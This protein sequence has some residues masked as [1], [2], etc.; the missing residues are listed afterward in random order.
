MTFVRRAVLVFALALAG[1]AGAEAPTQQPTLEARCTALP[2]A[3]NEALQAALDSA[4]DRAT[5]E[6]F[7]GQVAVI[8]G[9]AFI[10]SRNAGYADL[11]GTIPVSDATLFQVASITKYFTAVLMLRAAEQNRLTLDAPLAQFAP[12]ARIAAR[13]ATIAD[14]MAHRSGLGSSYAAEAQTNAN[15]AIAAIDAA[16]FDA[17]RAGVFNYSNDG[18]DLLAIAAERAYGEPFEVVLRR[19]VLDR[20]CVEHAAFWGDGR[21]TDPRHRAQALEPPSPELSQRNYGMLG[22]AGLLIT[23]RDLA[24]FQHSLRNGRVLS[25]ASIAELTTA[26]GTTSIGEAAYGAF[27]VTHPRLGRVLSARGFEDWGDNAILNEYLDC[28]VIVAVVTSRGPAESSGRPPFRN[29]LSEAAEA[30][31]APVCAS[32]AR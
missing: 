13:G 10:Y 4:V 2:L 20:G 24:T 30:A 15:A 6:G 14:L 31:L 32:A 5:A 11:E 8:R 25:D 12:G 18:Y 26:R 3:P 28:G 9:D 7:A 22:S 1:C 19:E 27:L 29:Q 23:A 17:A 21:L 16:P